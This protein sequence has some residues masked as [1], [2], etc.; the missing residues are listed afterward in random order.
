MLNFVFSSLAF[1]KRLFRVEDRDVLSMNGMCKRNSLHCSCVDFSC[2][3]QRLERDI[4]I[5]LS[6]S[7]KQTYRHHN[8][9]S[10]CF[11]SW[12]GS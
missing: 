8:D 3:C 7:V 1:I 11:T 2:F 4:F 10:H 6:S 12:A 9:I 5:V